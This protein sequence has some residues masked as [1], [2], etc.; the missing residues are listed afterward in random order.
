MH[1]LVT[2][3]SG[4][5]GTHLVNELKADGHEVQGWDLHGRNEEGQPTPRNFKDIKD[6]YLKQFDRVVHLAALA[7]VRKSFEAPDKWYE[8]NVEWSIDLFKLCNKLEI[9]CVYAS[10]SNVHNW[11]K[12]PYAGSKKAM[13][14]V[15]KATG[16][17]IGLRFTNV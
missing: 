13:E 9:P 3:S 5:I 10:S 14:A 4:F 11:H 17:H 7:D 8:T 15:A 12:N 2:G 6:V 1:I 16:K